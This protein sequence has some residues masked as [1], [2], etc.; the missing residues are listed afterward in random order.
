MDQPGGVV[1]PARGQLNRDNKHFPVCSRLRLRIWSRERVRPSRPASAYSLSKLRLNLV[2]IHGIRLD[3]RGGVLCVFEYWLSE[4]L[5]KLML[6]SSPWSQSRKVQSKRGKRTSYSS[7]NTTMSTADDARYIYYCNNTHIFICKYYYNLILF[8]P[9]LGRF[10]PK[11]GHCLSWR[12]SKLR[13]CRLD[14]TI[15]IDH[16]KKQKP[17]QLSLLCLDRKRLANVHHECGV[18]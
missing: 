11:F 17:L 13:W 16:Q 2:L 7:I 1:N 3:S 8:M 15:M 18:R 4:F 6:K 14:R 12:I 10:V 5:R 9:I